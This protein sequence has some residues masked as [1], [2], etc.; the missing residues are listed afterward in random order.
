MQ[1][2]IDLIDLDAEIFKGFT[3]FAHVRAICGRHQCFG[4]PAPSPDLLIRPE[5]KKSKRCDMIA[6]DAVFRPGSETVCDRNVRG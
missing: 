2:I 5:R 4:R 1:R 3:S 6:F